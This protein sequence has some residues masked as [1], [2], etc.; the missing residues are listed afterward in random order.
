MAKSVLNNAHDLCKPVLIINRVFHVRSG[1]KI[2]GVVLNRVFILRISC[3]KQGQAF[4]PQRLV[5]VEDPPPPPP[6]D[7][8]K[9]NKDCVRTLSTFQDI[10]TLITPS[11]VLST[12]QDG[13]QVKFTISTARDAKILYP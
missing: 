11:Q 13:G 3:P 5:L 10:G 7:Y 6:G 2:E 12:F 1:N 4:N 8:T 9:R